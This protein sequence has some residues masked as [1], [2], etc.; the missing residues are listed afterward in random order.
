MQQQQRRDLPEWMSPTAKAGVW[1]LDRR[2]ATLAPELWSLWLRL[3]AHAER[4]ERKNGATAGAI[5]RE[6][7]ERAGNEALAALMAAG[8]LRIH[9]AEVCIA[10]WDSAWNA[11]K[12]RR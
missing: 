5:P 6:A 12:V 3:I 1:D 4:N 7:C 9:A 11:G 10:E 8:L 2:R